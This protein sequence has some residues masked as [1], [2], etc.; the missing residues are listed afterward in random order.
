VVVITIVRTAYRYKRPPGKRKPVALE[1]PVV[2][3]AAYPAE[4]RHRCVR[5][6]A[7]HRHYAGRQQAAVPGDGA[8][9]V[10]VV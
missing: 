1:V 9:N 10:D 6:R 8:Q 5:A 4:P 3:K 7:G 2:V